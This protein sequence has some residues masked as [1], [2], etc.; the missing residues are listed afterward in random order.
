MAS[1]DPRSLCGCGGRQGA[2][3]DMSER[4]GGWDVSCLCRKIGDQPTNMGILP[5]TIGDIYIYYLI[6]GLEHELFDFPYIGNIIILT[7]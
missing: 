1:S 4:F 2:P 6:G 7:D 5:S 3:S